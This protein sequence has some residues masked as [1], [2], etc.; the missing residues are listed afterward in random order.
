MEEVGGAN[1]SAIVLV[2]VDNKNDV[3]PIFE[4]AFYNATI[5][6]GADEGAFIHQVCTCCMCGFMEPLNCVSGNGK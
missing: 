4:P 1:S 6:E 2:Y 3:S 5:V